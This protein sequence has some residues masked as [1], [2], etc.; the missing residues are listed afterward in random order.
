MA[1]F[2]KRGKTWD[3]RVRRTGHKDL[4]KSGFPNKRDARTWATEQ[5]NIINKGGM[6][7]A[8]NFTLGNLI[9]DFKEDR[10]LNKYQITVLDWWSKELGGRKLSTLHR[11]DF[12]KARNKLV[13][14]NGSKGTPIAPATVNRRMAAISAVISWHMDDNEDAFIQVNPAR[15]KSQP[16]DKPK[17]EPLTDE[18]RERL[19]KACAK[20]DQPALYPFVL[21][22]MASGARAG[23]LQGLRWQD[24]DLKRGIARL[25]DTK[26]GTD[27]VV[28]IQGKALE[29][30]K[31]Y[32]GDVAQMGKN[33]IFRNHTKSVPFNYRRSWGIAKDLAGMELR[34]HDLRHDAASHMAMAGVTLREIGE[35][36]GHKSAQM[37]QRY[38]HFYSEHIEALGKRL[39][40][41]I[42]K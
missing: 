5:E 8:S 28:P 12:I 18:Q 2:R 1:S 25:Y 17:V 29:A 20:S 30:L 11:R 23:E 34:F 7:D 6:V 13:K 35:V 36:L 31:E 40:D 39:A 24:V 42:D 14:V 38:S 33:F 15:I 3:V 19:L 27:R 4:T 21:V 10:P 41:K 32:R 37:S 9:E 26:N 16:E 22:A